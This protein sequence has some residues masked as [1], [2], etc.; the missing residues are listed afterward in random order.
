LLLSRQPVEKNGGAKKKKKEKSE[1]PVC[2]AYK[3]YFFSQQII[4]SY[5]NKSANSTFSHGFSDK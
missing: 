2:L 1:C 3:P 4:F 5:H